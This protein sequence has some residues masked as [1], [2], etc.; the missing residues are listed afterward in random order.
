LVPDTGLYKPGVKNCKYKCK[1]Q[2]KFNTRLVKNKNSL[3]LSVYRPG[4]T[5]HIKLQIYFSPKN[6]NTDLKVENLKRQEERKL[7]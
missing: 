2:K 5:A 6:L 7:E 3:T 1:K 4:I